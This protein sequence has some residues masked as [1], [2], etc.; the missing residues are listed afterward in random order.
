M[1]KGQT[2]TI[3]GKLYAIVDF[4]HVKLGKGGAVYQTKLKEEADGRFH[5]ERSTAV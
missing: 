2:I 4:Q 3:E 1:H 5:S